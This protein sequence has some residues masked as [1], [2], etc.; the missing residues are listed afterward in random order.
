[1]VQAATNRP[2]FLVLIGILLRLAGAVGIVPSREALVA[3]RVLARIDQD[4]GVVQSF[5]ETRIIGSEQLIEDLDTCFEGGRFP[6][7]YAV[8]EP[9]NNWQ[10]LDQLIQFGTGLLSGV[11]Q[12]A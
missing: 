2:R 3:I 4:Q 1:M 7:V 11:N 6:S 9:N 10:F 8:G 5:A 12:N